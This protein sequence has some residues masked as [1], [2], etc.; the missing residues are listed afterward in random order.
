MRRSNGSKTITQKATRG[1]SARRPRTWWRIVS[2]LP[3]LLLAPLGPAGPE[4]AL[5][6]EVAP[7]GLG[8]L[9]SVRF[10]NS[11][12]PAAQGPFLEGLALLHN[13]EYEDAALAF[14]EAQ[15]IDPG[16]ALAY[17]GE[18]MT[19]NHPIWQNQDRDAARAVLERLAPT[20]EARLAAAPTER[21]RAWLE[22]VEVLYGEG[23][24]E[25]RDFAYLGAMRRLQERWPDDHE[26][27][28]FHALAVLGSAHEGR[29]FA[30]YMRAAAI[31]EEVFR[32][33]PRHP[34]A[35]HYL[36]HSYDD[37]IHAPLGLRSARVYAD[38]APEAAHAQHMTSHIFVALGLWDE[39]VTAN[40]RARDVED[41]RRAELGRPPNVCGHYASWLEYGYLQQG[42]E[43]EARAV[44]DACHQRIAGGGT[45][46]GEQWYFARMRSRYLLDTGHWEPAVLAMDGDLGASVVARHNHR[47]VSAL[48]ALERGERETAERLAAEMAALREG[49]DS[50][51]LEIEG[52]E[53]AALLLLDAGRADEAVEKLRAAAEREAGMPFDFGPP[54]L[55]KPSHE[56][57]GE[58]LLGLDRPAAAREAFAAA[59][60]RAPR[61][62][63]SLLGLARAAVRA[64]D[65]A[66]AA[67]SY[68]TL[69]EI[70]RQ[71][72]RPAEDLLGRAGG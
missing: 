36:I 6:T 62:T 38:V 4:P 34:G 40:L 68:R 41:A 15:E 46:R 60:E 42:R 12:A 48:A 13:F 57:L 18:A 53:L 55:A 5:A 17:W 7:E 14:R 72:D 32:A 16:F 56:L 27:A 50:T 65:Q 11:G 35:L 30:T 9:G 70:W 52:E 47:F 22:A 26:A 59:L 51:N 29:D 19:H 8:G 21:E 1:S 3:A 2:L 20:R 44:L 54:P 63:A 31:A 45:I 43:R 39:V 67:E 69:R 71:A 37:P 61:R 58:V 23:E 28:A 66:T 24:K 25:A 64:G 33:N 49:E 10:P